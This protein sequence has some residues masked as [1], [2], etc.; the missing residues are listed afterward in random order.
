MK[1]SIYI[2]EEVEMELCQFVDNPKVNISKVINNLVM[3]G[4]ASYMADN[5]LPMKRGESEILI[6]LARKY[7]NQSS[8]YL[9][10]MAKAIF[11]IQEEI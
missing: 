7:P 5:T 2:H 11:T 1:R 6:E 8:F 9:M 4:V 10:A 3:L